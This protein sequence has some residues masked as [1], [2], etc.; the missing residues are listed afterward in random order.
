MSLAQTHHVI[1][2]LQN[3]NPDCS[4]DIIPITTR[5]DTDSRPLFA[6]GRRGIFEKE[7]DRAVAEKKIDFAVHSLKDVPSDLPAG[8]VL[9]CIPKR[10]PVDDVL[11]SQDGV[12]LEALPKNATVGTSSLRR[13]VQISRKRPDVTVRPIRGNIETRIN[14]MDSNGYDAV[15]LARAGINR[16][17][18]DVQYALL[19]VG[20][21]S[22][23]PGQ[24][25]LAIMAR[26]DD[27][28]TISMLKKIEDPDSRAESEA[29]RELSS[30]V[31]SGCR[32]PVGAHARTHGE[33]LTLSI[34][35]FSADGSRCIRVEKTGKKSDPVSLARLAG[36]ELQENGVGSLSLNWRKTVE[37]WNKK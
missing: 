17:G 34:A 20:D 28:K 7:I 12:S 14:K 21:F 1:D 22:P 19:H 11:I 13:A 3:A 18:L 26:K 4:Y 9:A 15:V 30:I 16:L 6:I 29:E 24:G 33:M 35:V 8:I 27:Y 25:A 36:K 32:F 23:S 37:E 2:E 10:G 31:D 5:G